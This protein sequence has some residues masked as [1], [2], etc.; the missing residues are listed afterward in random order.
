MESAKQ[1]YQL[2]HIPKAQ[3]GKAMVSVMSGGGC[4]RG[5]PRHLAL[6]DRGEAAQVPAA[7]LAQRKADQERTTVLASYSPPQPHPQTAVQPKAA[8]DAVGIPTLSQW[9]LVILASLVGAAS[10]RATSKRG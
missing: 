2:L 4:E 6:L 1:P 10:L 7:V 8:G 5:A 3:T 9:G